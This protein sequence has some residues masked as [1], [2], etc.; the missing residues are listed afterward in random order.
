MAATV[1]TKSHHLRVSNA[2]DRN[3]AAKLANHDVSPSDDRHPKSRANPRAEA[4]RPPQIRPQKGRLDASYR[5]LLLRS[6]DTPGAG[7]VSL[8][9]S[10]SSGCRRVETRT[11]R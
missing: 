10:A 1:P 5:L 4:A 9:E 7:A 6:E 2:A 11:E 3:A 8:G